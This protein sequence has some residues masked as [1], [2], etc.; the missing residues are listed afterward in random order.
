LGAAGGALGASGELILGGTLGGL[1]GGSPE[2]DLYAAFPTFAPKNMPKF[3]R[4]AE[5]VTPQLTLRFKESDRVEAD[6]GVD[7]VTHL[8]VDKQE[9]ELETALTTVI[10][11][12]GVGLN[13]SASLDKWEDAFTLKDFDMDDV[14]ISVEV[15]ADSSVSAG[16]QGTVTLKDGKTQ[17]TVIGLVSPDI[18]AI[19]LPK[20][21]VLE[22]KTNH[23]SLEGLMD[24]AD[25]FIGAT[26]DNPVAKAARGK[27]LYHTLQFDK[28][29]LIEFVQYKNSDG[30][31][32]D[33][34]VFLATPGATDPALDIDGWGVGV[35][36]R[37]RIAKKDIAQA[38]VDLAEHG[39]E[40]KGELLLDKLGPLKVKNGVIDAAAGLDDL[41]HLYINADAVLFGL[42]E[43]ITI[44]FSKEKMQFTEEAKF[45]QVFTS[46]IS[47]EA[48][49]AD[50]H[51]PN[52]EVLLE[53]KGDLLDAVL[54]GIEDE[55]NKFIK[56]YEGDVKTAEAKLKKAEKAVDDEEEKVDAAIKKAEAGAEKATQ[57]IESA[58]KKVNGIQTNINSDKDKVH[59]KSH[60]LHSLHWYEVGKAVKLGIEI[61]ALEVEIGGLYAGKATA[62][63]ALEVAKSATELTPVL[64]QAAVLAANSAFEVAKGAV[65]AAEVAAEASEYIFK[66][67]EKLIE[68]YRK[69]FQF[70]EA[71]FDGSLQA[72][73]GNK[74]IEMDVKFKVFGEDIDADLSF[75]PTKP[76]N[77]AKAVGDMTAKLAKE[78]VDGVEHAFFGGGSHSNKH[79][80]AVANW[81]EKNHATKDSGGFQGA[82]W[83]GQGPGGQTIPMK[84][85]L[86]KNVSLNRCLIFSKNSLKFSSCDSTNDDHLFRFS[87]N[88]D[89]V[90]VASGEKAPYCIAAQGVDKGA[91][92]VA[93]KCSG[94][95]QQKWTM[96]GTQLMLASGECAAVNKHKDLVLSDCAANDKAQQWA[97]TPIA[98]LKK[99]SETPAS[100]LYTVSLRDTA[101]GTCMDV[102]DKIALAYACDDSDYQVFNL[103]NNSQLRVLQSCVRA[104]SSKSGAQI[105][106]GKCDGKETKWTWTG[107]HMQVKGSKS[108]LCIARGK[109]LPAPFDVTPLV[110]AAC[111][112]KEAAWELEPTNVDPKGRILPAYHMIRSKTYSRCVEIRTKLQ[113]DG[114]PIPKTVLWDCD[115]DFNQS[116]SFRWNGEIRSL[117]KCLAQAGSGVALNDCYQRPSAFAITPDMLKSGG[118][119]R[120]AI[121]D[122]RWKIRKDGLIQKVGANL[123]LSVHPKGMQMLSAGQL[124]GGRFVPIPPKPGK[125]GAIGSLLSLQKCKKTDKLQQWVVVNTLPDGSKAEPYKQL[126]HKIDN[127]ERCLETSGDS[128]VRRL[129]AR[130]CSSSSSYQQF[131]LSQNGEVRQMGRCVTADAAKPAFYSGVQLDLQECR[132]DDSQK[133]AANDNGLLMQPAVKGTQRC[134]V[135][136]PVFTP[137]AELF[138]HLPKDIQSHMKQL[139]SFAPVASGPCHLGFQNAKSKRCMRQRTDGVLASGKCDA[140]NPTKAQQ[141]MGVVDGKLT[142]INLSK[143]KLNAPHIWIDKDL[144]STLPSTVS[145]NPGTDPKAVADI[146][147]AYAASGFVYEAKTGQFKY[148]DKG[149]TTTNCLATAKSGKAPSDKKLADLRAKYAAAVAN[150]TAMSVASQVNKA[151]K[152]K[153][154]AAQKTMKTAL[155]TYEKAAAVGTLTTAKC[156]NTSAQKWTSAPAPRASWKPK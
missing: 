71:K 77:I 80:E 110:L 54:G 66:G 117:G 14:A 128:N 19:G 149:K 153:A 141:V 78:A 86:Y 126:A 41:P 100:T 98:D 65:T 63:A 73:L 139:P 109:H 60:E 58:I 20:E 133:F 155:A 82:S 59:D 35:E 127:K 10:A 95:P 122:Q 81:A 22:V 47:A 97:T 144:G 53:F 24:L 49:V 29:P 102:A 79:T 150:W 8:K 67:L 52:F 9:L 156:S 120:H 2:I 39:F 40:M 121:N 16:F 46:V 104:N 137:G 114:I 42:E 145:I 37:L 148:K 136:G 106:L 64:F 13:I 25:V 132:N 131:A 129:V 62:T 94:A 56:E 147:K 70:T 116:F 17:F 3:L 88:G 11:T 5:D 142:F 111:S 31:A 138:K 57:K 105:F 28:L 1:F 84:G 12:S 143:D 85:A 27:G 30:E 15:D 18:A 51:N 32:E 74:P 4:A 34:Q 115:G 113:V 36:G 90:A 48:T 44:E 119:N 69:N 130:D 108:K 50:I 23:V 61:A 123:C 140:A 33:V 87:P 6:I 68:A 75:T 91:A 112:A 72:L 135:E 93:A 103:N 99:L 89:L 55:L 83:S 118:K 146:V 7:L 134:I 107:E 45:G 43:A 26:G 38:K 125:V 152:S 151:L 124:T 96:S 76:E 21:L 154:D 92:L 101:T